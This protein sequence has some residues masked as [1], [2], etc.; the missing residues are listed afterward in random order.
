[1][2][3]Q[4]LFYLILTA[5]KNEAHHLLI[6][7]NTLNL[8]KKLRKNYWNY[9]KGHLETSLDN[10]EVYNYGLN[11]NHPY[12]E[13][14]FSDYLSDID[15]ALLKKLAQVDNI[16]LEVNEDALSNFHSSIYL[17]ANTPPK[18]TSMLK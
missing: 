11:N 14:S 8:Y 6:E 17:E 18:K 4:E 15:I 16:Y 7:K 1:M 13:V 3:L 10:L 2:S 12:L 5:D 9:C